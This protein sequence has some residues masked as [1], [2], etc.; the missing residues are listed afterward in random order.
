MPRMH[1]PE[2]LAALIL[3]TLAACAAAPEMR[4]APAPA[5][6][7]AA[8]APRPPQSPAVLPGKGLAQHPFLYAG[9]WDTRK[10]DQSMFLV[11]EGKIVCMVCAA[12]RVA[13]PASQTD[14]HSLRAF[15]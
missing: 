13:M 9:E 3:A 4:A 1:A 15:R 7:S 14:R 8:S 2:I 11:K 12:T 10:T 5:T 6:T